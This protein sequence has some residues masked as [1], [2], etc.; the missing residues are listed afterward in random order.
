MTIVAVA[1]AAALAAAGG[2]PPAAAPAPAAQPSPEAAEAIRKAMERELAALPPRPF[3]TPG[4]IEGAVEAAAPPEVKVQEE[5]EEITIPLGTEQPVTCSAVAKRLDAAAAIWRMAESAKENVKLVLAQPTEVVAVEGSPLVLAAVVYQAPSEKGPM[6]GLLKLGVYVHDAHSLLCVHDEPGYS[7]SF[8]RVVKGLA[9]SL[10]GGGE[11]PRAGARFVQL[12]VMRIGALAI[13]YAEQVVWDRKGGGRLTSQYGAQLLPRGPAN[14]VAVDSYSGEEVDAKDLLEKG[15]YA[16]VTNGE[17]DARMELTRRKDGK[18]FAY[19][20]EKDGKPLAG[21][22]K[23]SAGLS[24]D[25]WFARRF[26]RSAPPPKG[27][28]RHEAYSYEANPVAALPIVYRL[29]AAGPRRARME[30]GP[31]Q[32]SGDLDDHGLFRSAEMPVGPTKLV[33]ERLSSRGAP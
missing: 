32:L 5:V 17:V 10:K 8:A 33:V 3:R 19:D 16:H 1:L 9:A 14:L 12:S 26:A 13:G 11:D 15:T 24:T 21:K 25:L 28:V 4:G 6:V 18:T 31:I 27:A 7:K 22:F 29:D 30:I 20:G 2:D 23:T